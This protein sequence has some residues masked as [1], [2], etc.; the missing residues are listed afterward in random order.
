MSKDAAQALGDYELMLRIRRFEERVVELVNADEIAG[1][2]HEYVGQEAVAVGVC[3]ALA[4]GDVITSTHRGHGHVLAKGGK[5]K[6]MLAELLGRVDGY[7]KGRGGSMHI[8]DV[9]SG[10]YG[11]NGIVGA[12]A[13]I[14]CGVAFAMKRAGW[15]RVA[16]AFFGDGGINQ[17]VVLESFNLAAIWD[18]PVVFV[19]ENNMYAQTTPVE[20]SN[21]TELTERG[22]GT[23]LPSAQVDGMDL[24]AVRE[25]AT[26]AVQR[27]R[28]GGG[29]S[30]LECRTYRFVGH[31]TAERLMK[32][33]YR[34]DE[35]VARWRERDPL[36]LQAERVRALGVAERELDAVETRVRARLDEATAYARASAWPDRSTLFDYVYSTTYPGFPARGVG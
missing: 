6:P 25:A 35:E 3:S 31:Q 26:G 1:V 15:G 13:P 8:A 23:G 7:N 34:E 22:Q 17:G 20:S 14:A 5:E 11:A 24:N 33:R 21:R 10:M 19:C 27:A 29:P 2:T 28:A 9:A 16:V 32:L 12:G 36:V 30:F 4:D 18:L